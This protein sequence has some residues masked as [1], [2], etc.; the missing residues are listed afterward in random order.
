[1]SDNVFG[2]RSFSLREIPWHRLGEV[3]EVEKTAVEA[4]EPMM[5]DVL[6]EN[7]QTTMGIEI[8]DR[9]ILR[10][11]TADD[12]EYRNF[13]IVGKEYVLVDPSTACELWDRVV[14]R[15][16]ETLGVLGLGAT[17]FITTKL[18]EIDIFGDP[19]ENYLILENPLTS[20]TSVEAMTSPQRVVCA[21]TLSV[22]KQIAVEHYSIRHDRQVLLHMEDWLSGIYERAVDKVK[23][24]REVFEI[25]AKTEVK[26]DQFQFVM[27]Q[28]YPIPHKPKWNAPAPVME[29]RML[30]WDENKAYIERARAGA[31]SLFMGNA[32]GFDLKGFEGTAWGAYNSIA[33]WEDYRPTN[34]NKLPSW[35]EARLFGDRAAVKEKAFSVLEDFSRN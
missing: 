32:T 34:Q 12:P 31:T 25:F 19:I 16:V 30:Y 18:P 17:L 33:E 29:Q 14:K 26:G 8:E 20:G 6:I 10:T 5:Y 15:P 24:L 23:V 7:L 3:S 1:M 27:E 22:A 11:P 21:N 9:V 28:V 4:F 2:Q 35:A 13:G